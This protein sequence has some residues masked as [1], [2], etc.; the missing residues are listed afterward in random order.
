MW[1]ADRARQKHDMNSA[2]GRIT[3]FKALLMPSIRRLSDRLE[4]AA[5]ATEVAD[6]LGIDRNLVLNEF[7]RNPA[8][9][10]EPVVRAKAEHLPNAERILLRSLIGDAEVRQTL[11]PAIEASAAARRLVVWPI[12]EV[13]SV[14]KENGEEF[15]FTTIELRLASPLK[16]LLSAVL[17]ADTN[18]EVFS[19]EQ[20]VAYLRVLD[21]GD[22]KLEIES[23]RARLK[24]AES[25]GDTAEAFRLVEELN[26]L[27]RPGDR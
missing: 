4:R 11:L 15:S 7:R 24:E 8:P 23:I 5:V 2:E 10:S 12:L 13:L 14:L 3:G 25:K 21:A 26:R 22:R 18:G 9:R 17:F 6:Y 1:L 20:A 16:E 27:Q 19:L